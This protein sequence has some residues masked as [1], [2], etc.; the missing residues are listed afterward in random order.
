MT[1]RSF[2]YIRIAWVA[3]CLAVFTV[4]S[5][6]QTSSQLQGNI[7]KDGQTSPVVFEENVP[8]VIAQ[9][10]EPVAVQLEKTDGHWS[11]TLF[12]VQA[13]RYKDIKSPLPSDAVLVSDD[14]VILLKYIQTYDPCSAPYLLFSKYNFTLQIHCP[15]SVSTTS[16]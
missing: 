13:M 7:I 5:F 15:K 6:A 11:L 1:K 2:R 8:L 10:D 14:G 16:D 4:A 12:E 3:L 9:A